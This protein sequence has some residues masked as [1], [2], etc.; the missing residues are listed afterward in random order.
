MSAEPALSLACRDI[1][2]GA[3]V[4][5][6][7][8]LF[9]SSRN[10]QTIA[11]GL[12]DRYR[13]I[14]V[15]LRNHGASPHAAE[16]GYGAMAADV[17]ALA[18]RLALPQPVLV[19][20]SMGGKVAMTAA[21]VQP[22]RWRMLA[23]VDIAPVRYPVGFAELVDAMLAVAASA[24]SRRTQAE[25]MLRAAEPD[26]AVRN[27]LLQNLVI[28]DGRYAWRINLPAIREALPEIA[29]FPDIDGRFDGPVLFAR[30]ELSR[31]ILPEHEPIIRAHFP[32]A[33]M[34]TI[35]GAGHWPHADSPEA[36]LGVLASWLAM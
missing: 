1:G 24:P 9:G 28:R 15:D 13:V 8:G 27:L 30:G 19:G 18:D 20:H 25:E 33:R 17:C 14:S 26:P 21:L 23:V 31:A 12:A 7:H 2:Q 35:A 34:V 4:I 3:A 5:I 6:L 36:F 16:M 32:R 11:R 22:L 10:W 29:G